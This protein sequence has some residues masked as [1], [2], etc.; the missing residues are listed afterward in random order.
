ME[1]TIQSP[2]VGSRHTRLQD[3]HEYKVKNGWMPLTSEE[4]EEFMKMVAEFTN[5]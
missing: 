2:P 3:V 5:L 1:K 4:K